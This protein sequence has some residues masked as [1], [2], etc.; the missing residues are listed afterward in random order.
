MFLKP[1][2]I[3]LLKHIILPSS[4]PPTRDSGKERLIRAE[5]DEDLVKNSSFESIQSALSGY[6]QFSSHES[7]AVARSICTPHTNQQWQF[8]PEET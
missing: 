3:R 7:A 8:N 5:E 1:S 6:Q 4:P 2:L